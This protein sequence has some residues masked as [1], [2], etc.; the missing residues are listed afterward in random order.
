ML[1][2]ALTL[3]LVVL[4][5]GLCQPR[6]AERLRLGRLPGDLRFRWRGRDYA[7]PFAT[8]LLFSLLAALL[9]RLV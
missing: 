1:K 5:I 2:W 8:T 9:F 7:F 3:L 4:V 6:L